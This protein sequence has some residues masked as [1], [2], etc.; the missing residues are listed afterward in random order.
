[1]KTQLKFLSIL[2]VFS[3]FFYSCEKDADGVTNIET[4]IE[5][6]ETVGAEQAIPG[7]YIVIY[8]E[9]KSLF[10]KS[11]GM[12]AKSQ[13][14]L[15]KYAI[16]EDNIKQTYSSAIQGFHI[17][18][19]SEEQVNTLKNDPEI[20][21]IQPNYIRTLDVEM[22]KPVSQLPATVQDKAANKGSWLPSGDFLP[23]G[24]NRVGRANGTGRTCWI[25]DSGISPHRDLNIDSNRSRS[26]VGGSWQ[27]QNGHGTHVAGTVAAKNNGSGVIG[28]AY[29]ATVVSVRV[30][31]AQGSGSDA[32]ILGGVDYVARNARNGD[33]WNYSIGYRNRHTNVATDN[34]FRNLERT[35]YGAMAAGNSN[36]DTQYYSPQRLRTRNSWNVGNM[37]R[38]DR[39]A[40]TSNYGRSV[41]RWAPGTQVWSTWLNGQFNRISGT[42]MAS[43]HVAGILLLRGNS[44]GTDGSVSKGGHSAPIA[45]TN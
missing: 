38:G 2:T 15:S 9:D 1:M 26:F 25:I 24:I 14:T 42:S 41:D 4:G 40:G 44:T 3:L 45:T 27:D 16:A 35:T 37:T 23:W 22:G 34:A 21:Y 20:A 29:G 30:L 33:T 32:A 19:L 36:D 17:E 5:T 7:E 6:T 10:G 13:Q 8:K 28:V 39:P 31:N 43:P 12:K 11:A 18:N